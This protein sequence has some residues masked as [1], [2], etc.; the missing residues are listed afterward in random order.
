MSC[1]E[2]ACVENRPVLQ[3][4]GV[5]L[6]IVGDEQEEEKSGSAVEEIKEEEFSIENKNGSNG[7]LASLIQE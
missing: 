4:N 1:V 6:L 5:K 7:D 2:T 3:I